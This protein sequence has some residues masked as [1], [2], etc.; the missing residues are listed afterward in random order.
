VGSIVAEQNVHESRPD[1]W[2]ITLP[3]LTLHF[4]H[5]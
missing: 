5:L 2:T 3:D 4:G 1:G